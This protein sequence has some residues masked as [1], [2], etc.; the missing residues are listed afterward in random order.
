MLYLENE[1]GKEK[2][3]LV[4]STAVIQYSESV[5]HL[6]YWLF[7]CFSA[8][9]LL[10]LAVKS[11]CVCVCAFGVSVCACA[12]TCN[13][14]V[15]V[16]ATSVICQSQ[17]SRPKKLVIHQIW[18][19]PGLSL[20]WSLL[21]SANLIPTCL[22]PETLRQLSARRLWPGSGALHVLDSEPIPHPWGMPVP[23]LRRALQALITER[24]RRSS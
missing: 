13:L 24:T 19:L 14:V 22:S 20:R 1:D 7:C 8:Q 3:I 17:L 4:P 21:Q 11:V 12:Y 18:P 16:I 9:F 5:Y 23:A 2:D 10:L 15:T 6:S